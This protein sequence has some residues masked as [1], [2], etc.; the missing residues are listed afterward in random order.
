MDANGQY[1]QGTFCKRNCFKHRTIFD[2]VRS[3]RQ[4]DT[5]GPQVD[6][7]RD[8]PHIVKKMIRHPSRQSQTETLP[9]FWIV[10]S[11][12]VFNRVRANFAEKMYVISSMPIGRQLLG[13]SQTTSNIVNMVFGEASSN[14]PGLNHVIVND[15]QTLLQ[16]I[17]PKSKL[18][19]VCHIGRRIVGRGVT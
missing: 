15:G 7:S 12:I 11:N 2:A 17:T 10:V 16:L 19:L 1:W 3:I 8:L 18:K 6:S 13:R 5:G 4:T 9:G 14:E